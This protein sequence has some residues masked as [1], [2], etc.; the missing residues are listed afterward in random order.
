MR[1]RIFEEQTVFALLDGVELRADELRAV[2]LE[3]AAIGQFDGEVQ[4]GLSA[5]R[6]K[7]G[8][9]AGTP[10]FGEHFGFD[11]DDLFR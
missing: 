8:E 6:G 5:D 10:A 2:L 4:S 3:D 11:A 7:H 9:D 1:H